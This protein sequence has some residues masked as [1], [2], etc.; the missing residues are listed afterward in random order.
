MS[1]FGLLVDIEN[2]T[3]PK[4]SP[5]AN[6]HSFARLSEPK[7]SLSTTDLTSLPSSAHDSKLVSR[8]SKRFSSH[9][10]VDLSELHSEKANREA[11]FGKGPKPMLLSEAKVALYSHGKIGVLS[12]RGFRFF[13]RWVKRVV[14][15]RGR[16][17]A[18]GK[19]GCALSGGC[20]SW[21]RGSIEL[22]SAARIRLLSSP[23]WSF[24]IEM[25][26]GSPAWE[27]SAQTEEQRA[28]WLEAITK[29]IR[30]IERCSGPATLRGLGSVF[31]HFEIGQVLGKGR[32]G[33]VRRCV[34]ISTGAAYAVKVVNKY[35]LLCLGVVN[36]LSRASMWWWSHAMS[37]FS[38]LCV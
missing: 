34:N 18:Y 32:F 29:S 22:T 11:E 9:S 25:G 24:A 12:K 17:L 13:R 38:F 33:V 2:D 31:D 3:G 15:L 19:I 14:C 23:A 16:M 21:P 20:I 10:F 5:P 7:K 1:D 26:D 27:L 28:L 4:E 8:R 30:L 36:I 35:V 37:S 6:Q